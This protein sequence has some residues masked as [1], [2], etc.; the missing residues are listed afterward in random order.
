[1]SHQF[2]FHMIY[3]KSSLSHIPNMHKVKN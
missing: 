3:K 2:T 1:M